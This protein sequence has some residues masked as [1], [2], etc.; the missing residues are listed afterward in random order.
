MNRTD[1]TGHHPHRHP[2]T[3][4]RLLWL[5]TGLTPGFAGVEAFVGR[6]AGSLALIADAGALALAAVA[7]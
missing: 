6:W 7:A 2:E 4:R 5:A 1:R 3:G